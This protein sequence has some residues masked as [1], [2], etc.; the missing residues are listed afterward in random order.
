MK[1]IPKE[2]EKQIIELR[3]EGFTTAHLMEKFNLTHRD[4][5]GVIAKH[6]KKKGTYNL[7]HIEEKYIVN[8]EL[9]EEVKPETVLDLF[10]GTGRFWHTNYSDKA[11]VIDNDT[12]KNIP[13]LL[14]CDALELLRLFKKMGTT[15]DMVD[16]DPY[17]CSGEYIELAIQVA[18]KALVI[19][20]GSIKKVFRTP[21]LCKGFMQNHYGID[22]P[23][24]RD[25]FND[26]IEH[27]IKV[28]HEKYHKRL[29]VF[30]YLPK[31]KT[32]DRVWFTIEEED[33]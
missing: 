14:H 25:A 11:K 7:D 16:V 28:A 4:I 10:C 17:G 3:N 8:A 20:D 26:V 15:F 9:F 21:N 29:T 31:W 12:E 33:N 23:L 27:I 13:C 32:C 6:R 24:K 22:K 30:T 19:T 2:I 1:R 18:K 5:E